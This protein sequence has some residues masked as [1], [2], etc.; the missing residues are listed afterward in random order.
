VELSVDLLEFV[1]G[2]GDPEIPRAARSPDRERCRTAEPDEED[3]P[4]PLPPHRVAA[5]LADG[6]ALDA[7]TTEAAARSLAENG[8]VILEPAAPLAEPLVS[9]ELCERCADDAVLQCE[10]LLREV[11]RRMGINVF[12]K[13]FYTAEICHRVDAGLRYDMRVDLPGADPC[14]RA[15]RDASAR[16]ALPVIA[17]SGLLGE[18]A[19]AIHVDMQGCVTSFPSACDQH[20]HPDGAQ[21]GLVNCFVPLIDVDNRNGSTE[22]K[23]ATHLMDGTRVE[24]TA[25]VTSNM[26]RGSVL[27][28]DF[29]THHRGRAHMKSDTPRPVAYTVFGA[30]G[31]HDTHNFGPNDSLWDMAELEPPAAQ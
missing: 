5:S 9:A 2:V 16:L 3:A 24:R 20:F 17:R 18:R 14:W 6:G 10:R 1:L 23:P 8:F 28:F 4:A 21:M 29:R 15:L 19:A 13:R 31:V 26:R 27:L 11:S 25:G 12:E 7:P 30:P 22:L